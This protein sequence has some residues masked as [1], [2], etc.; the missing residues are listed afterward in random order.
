LPFVLA[1]VSVPMKTPIDGNGLAMGPSYGDTLFPRQLL[2]LL[3][4]AWWV[5]A[6]LSHQDCLLA[7]FLDI[8]LSVGGSGRFLTSLSSKPPEIAGIS[9]VCHLLTR[10]SLPGPGL[11]PHS[12]CQ[13][14]LPDSPDLEPK[15]KYKLSASAFLTHVCF[16]GDR[17]LT[18]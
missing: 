17:V 12:S 5:T 13:L 9:T 7:S 16:F 2:P 14:A 1:L 3:G 11:L 10:W 8:W 18:K 6:V 4:S 15:S